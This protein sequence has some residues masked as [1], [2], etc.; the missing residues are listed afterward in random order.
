MSEAMS[1]AAPRS[2]ERIEESAVAIDIIDASPTSA[3]V[4]S[5]G[6]EICSPS[7]TIVGWT[8]GRCSF[9]DTSGWVCVVASKGDSVAVVC[10]SALD[11]EGT[12]RP[13][14]EANEDWSSSCVWMNVGTL[15]GRLC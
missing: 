1:R 9:V 3:S 14:A 5:E 13:C 2:G 15:G 8:G 6:P 7:E 12:D 4:T 11:K 10:G